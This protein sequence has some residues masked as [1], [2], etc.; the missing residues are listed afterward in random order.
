MPLIPPGRRR[1]FVLPLRSRARLQS[2]VLPARE[3]A[4]LLRR[5]RARVLM[6]G[7]CG[8]EA[9]GVAV[10]RRRLIWLLVLRLRREARSGHRERQRVAGRDG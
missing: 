7:R 9:D 4:A 1:T 6:R 2:R 5:A 10:G 8:A 3:T